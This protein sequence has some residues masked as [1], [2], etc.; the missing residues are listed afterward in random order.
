MTEV[1]VNLLKPS[2]HT[3]VSYRGALLRTT[4]TYALVRATW[5]RPLVDLGYVIFAPGDIFIEHY[6]TDRWYNVFAIHTATGQLKGW[7]CNVTR[8]AIIQGTTIESE[9]LEL[10]LFVSPDRTRLLRLDEDEFTARDFANS[11]PAT[12]AAA[13]AALDELERLAHAGVPPFANPAPPCEHG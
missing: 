7:Y 2:K 1:T 10:D 6:Y 8:P 4:P 13:L 11:E 3:V 9:D 12:Y 5:D